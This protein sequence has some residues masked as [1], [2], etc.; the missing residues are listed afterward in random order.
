[1]FVIK[2]LNKVF[3]PRVPLFFE[4]CTEIWNQIKESG[5]KVQFLHVKRRYNCWADHVGRL[6]SKDRPQVHLADCDISSFP[7]VPEGE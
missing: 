3:S 6:V 4:V 7:M 5:W 1:M 2:L